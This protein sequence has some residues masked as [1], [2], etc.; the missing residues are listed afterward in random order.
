MQGSA[1]RARAPAASSPRPRPTGWRE[2]VRSALGT[3]EEALNDSAQFDPRHSR[4]TFRIHMSD[5][6]EGRFLPE[7]M[8]ML[9]EQAPGVRLETMPLRRERDRRRA[10]QRPH[11]LRLRLP[12]DG[13][14][15]A[16]DA[17]AQ[18][19]LHRAAARGP[20]VHAPP[21]H[22]K[23]LLEALK[24]LEFVAVRTHA[25]T[26][27]H[28]AA[29]EPGRPAAPDHRALHGAA[30]DR[31]GDRPGGGDAAQHRP[32]LCAGGRL[33]DRR[34]AVPAARFRRVAA[35]EQALRIRSRPTAGCARR[36]WRFTAPR[37]VRRCVAAAATTRQRRRS[38][39]WRSARSR[40]ARSAGPWQFRRNS[41][42]ANGTCSV[43]AVPALAACCSRCC[44]W[45]HS[46][47]SP[48]NARV[49]RTHV[50]VIPAEAESG[51]T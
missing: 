22:G 27:A 46:T 18:G 33:R 32:R 35:L 11:R 21:P 4:K 3:L 40:G 2:A 7:L 48:C 50:L 41:R 38:G 24:L 43:V 31:P 16:E 8:V 9:R 47:G 5:I 45:T 25:D 20:S 34:A 12:A 23:A 28:P 49:R 42:T 10:G 36:S 15:D 13:E 14:G 6:G 30:R 26:L 44:P 1:V 39:G 51:R 29:A 37:A 17:A 19:P